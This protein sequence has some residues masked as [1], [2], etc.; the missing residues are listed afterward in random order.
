MPMQYQVTHRI[1]RSPAEV[2][3]TLVVQQARNHP[4]WEPEVLE[5]RREGP[6]ASGLKGI[7]VRKENGRVS[8]VPFE[9]VDVVPDRRVEI[10]SGSGG[11][12]LHLIWE[13]NP[14]GAETDFTLTASAKLTGAL[15]LMTPLMSL[16]F[17]GRS[18][19]ITN[20]MV[21]LLNQAGQ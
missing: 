17:P 21:A 10:R 16:G 6:I 7:M 15:W 13:M 20:A 11:F 2:F 19:R 5:I 18:R 9:F 3:D 4:R 12:H 8:E 14:A 1:H